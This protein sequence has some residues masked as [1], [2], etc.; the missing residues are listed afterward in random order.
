M[1][2]QSRSPEHLAA[3]TVCVGYIFGYS[4]C[5]TLDLCLPDHKIKLNQL[6]V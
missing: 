5:Y 2:A 1:A 4:E 6:K 3:V